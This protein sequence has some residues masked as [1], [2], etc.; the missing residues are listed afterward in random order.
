MRL[1]WGCYGFGLEA[2]TFWASETWLGLLI[3]TILQIG[4]AGRP[5]LQQRQRVHID[6]QRRGAPLL[7]PRERLRAAQHLVERGAAGG[8]DQELIPVFPTSTETTPTSVTL[9][10]SWPLAIIRV[11]SY[12]RGAPWLPASGAS[13]FGRGNSVMIT[14][15]SRVQLCVRF[16]ENASCQKIPKAVSRG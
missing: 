14:K 7:L 16:L 4:Q 3:G 15:V 5:V 1:F 11:P 8:L 13:F 12:R 2:G 6:H 9:G 10:I